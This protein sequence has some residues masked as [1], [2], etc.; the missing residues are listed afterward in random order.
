MYMKPKNKAIG[1]FDHD[2]SGKKAKDDF[3]KEIQRRKSNKIHESLKA[4]YYHP[5]GTY[6]SRL[7]SIAQIEYSIEELFSP[8]NW[9]YAKDNDWLGKRKTQVEYRDFDQMN[10]SL[11]DH[12][13]DK[14]V[15][16]EEVIVLQSSVR[17]C[18]KKDFS[19]Y[20]VRNTSKDEFEKVLKPTLDECLKFLGLIK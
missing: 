1:I 2:T 4:I 19:N 7:L 18:N 11:R 8:N 14:N 6:I 5:I 3:N 13:K 12:F 10:K 9:K 16:E 17:E 15:S 20:L